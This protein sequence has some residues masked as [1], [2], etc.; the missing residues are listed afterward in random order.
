[1]NNKKLK[2]LFRSQFAEKLMDLGNI[3]AAAFVFSQFLTEKKFPF[4]LFT[5]GFI[6]TIISYIASYIVSE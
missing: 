2:K 5:L 4:Y 6:L 1:M 3:I